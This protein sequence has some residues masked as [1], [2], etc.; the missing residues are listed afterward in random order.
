V[1][2]LT[3][4][5]DA[6]LAQQSLAF[7]RLAREG[8]TPHEVSE[9]VLR[10]GVQQFGDRLTL[11]AS[12]NDAVLLHLSQRVDPGIEVVFVDTGFHFDETWET[13][14]A[15]VKKYRPALRIVSSGMPADDRWR[16]DPDG[17]CAARKVAP[18]E[19]VLAERDAWAAG[20]RR[21]ESPGRAMTPYVGRDHR[22]LVKLAP[23]AGWSDADVDAYIAR[24]DVPVNPLIDQGY[25]SIGCW[26]CTRKPV[27]GDPRSGRW[28]GTGKTECGLHLAAEPVAAYS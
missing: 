7:E 13:V 18:L 25:P 28:A 9:A 6:E 1:P 15:V 22:G 24:Y 16:T 14:G 8:A 23:L 10:W 3:L 17:C 5:S 12:M 2:V 27:D 11:A 4:L 21:V 26:P 19:A 20:L